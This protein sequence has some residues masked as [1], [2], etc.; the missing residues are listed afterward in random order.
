TTPPGMNDLVV[1]PGDPNPGLRLLPV[2]KGQPNPGL[3]LLG[4]AGAG[5]PQAFSGTYVLPVD[6]TLTNPYGASQTYSSG[7][8]L[9]IGSK[10][11]G[12]D[13]ATKAGTDVRAP[14]GGTV[15]RVYNAKNDDSKGQR[16]AT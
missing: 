2:V 12:V 16:D 8:N 1:R 10:N 13:L 6:G 5:G 14:V 11:N 4:G 3:R 7:M 9:N 15:L